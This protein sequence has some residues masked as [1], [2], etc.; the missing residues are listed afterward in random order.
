[1]KLSGVWLPVMTPFLND[2]I[3]FHSYDGL[4]DYY[5]S[6]GISGLI[7]L[8]TTGE[9]PVITEME[10]EKI[11]DRTLEVNNRR[12]PVYVGAGG[13]FT[14]KVIKTL[15]VVEK[16]SVEGILSVCPYYNRPDQNGLY[17][18]FLKISEATDRNIII[19]NIPYRTGVNLEN[20]TLFKL[21]AQENIVGV[22][23]SCGDISQTLALLSEKPENFSVLTG[24]DILF[25]TN[26]VNGGEGGILAA[27]H[28]NTEVFL[29]VFNLIKE[30]NHRSAFHR[31]QEINMMIPMLFKEP[32]PGPLKYCLNRLNF[33]RSSETRL[34][35]TGISDKL[36]NELNESYIEKLEE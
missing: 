27:S 29:D 12:V 16:Y 33:I 32:N 6:K 15:K 35:L 7:P 28:L 36:K 21:A 2:E 30:N 5:I 8:G 11:I 1:M 13:N 23:D 10:F 26:V 9:G 34:P 20:E 19:Y 25:Y 17:E 24:E 4:I 22:K 3:D 18:H 14:N 31:W